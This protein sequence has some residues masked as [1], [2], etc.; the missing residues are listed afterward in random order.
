MLYGYKYIVVNLSLMYKMTGD[1]DI[2]ISTAYW[3]QCNHKTAA[4]TMSSQYPAQMRPVP[5]AKAVANNKNLSMLVNI[6]A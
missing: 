3:I 4:D 5:A 6:L 2:V 1:P